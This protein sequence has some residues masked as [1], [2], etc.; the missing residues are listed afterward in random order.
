MWIQSNNYP[1][2]TIPDEV[3]NLAEYNGEI[4]ACKDAPGF[5]CESLLREYYES[6]WKEL[7]GSLN[8]EFMLSEASSLHFN[9]LLNP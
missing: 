5:K 2:E 3:F 6:L 1:F 8:D 9:A 4:E 7:F